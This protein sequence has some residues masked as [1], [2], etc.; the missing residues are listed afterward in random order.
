MNRFVGVDLAT[1]TGLVI[2]DEPGNVIVEKEIVAKDGEDLERF[3]L[4]ASELLNYITPEDTVC[5]EGFS[6]GSSGRGLSFTHGLGYLV[7]DR[8]DTASIPFTLIP[9]GCLKKFAADKGNAAKE[10]IMREV[11]RKFEY[12][13]DSNNIVDAYVLAQM[14]RCKVYPESYHKYQVEALKKA[15]VSV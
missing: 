15:G 1:H 12:A 14:A 11:W 13:N 9:P 5:I 10:I 7:R 8:L 4:V 3:R 6:F 2:L